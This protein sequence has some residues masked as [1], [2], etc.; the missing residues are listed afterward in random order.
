MFSKDKKTL[1]WIRNVISAETHKLVILSFLRAVQA[2]ALTAISLSLKK[3][4]DAAV[5]RDEQILKQCFPMLLGLILLEIILFAVTKYLSG[6][7][8]ARAEM[9]LRKHAFSSLMLRAYDK[10][11]A[12]HS[13]DWTGRITTESRIIA[14]GIQ[15][16]VPELTGILV[17]LG[18]AVATLHFIIPGS[19]P[20]ILAAGMLM[21]VCA[22]FLRSSLIRYHSAIQISDSRACGMLQEQISS[23]AVIRSFS[24]ENRSA[25]MMRKEFDK[26]QDARRDWTRFIS[27]C[28]GGVHGAAQLGFLLGTAVCCFGVFNGQM[29]PGTMTALI[30][31]VQ[32]LT[33]PISGLFGIVPNYYAIIACAE[34]LQDIDQLPLDRLADLISVDEVRRYYRDELQEFGMQDIS[35]SYDPEHNEEPVLD[36]F[37][38]KVRKGEFLALTGRSGS[39]KSTVL[40][41][42]MGLYKPSSGY[43]YLRNKDGSEIELDASWRMLFAYIPQENGLMSGTIREGIC[44]GNPE[45]MGNDARIRQALETACAWNFVSQLDGGIDAVLGEHGFGL[46]E[47]QMQRLAIARALLAGRPVMMLDEATSALDASTETELL[48]NLKTLSDV[49]VIAVTHRP[50]AVELADRVAA[51]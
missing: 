15:S 36:G 4:V 5:S 34:R 26:V 30:S 42:L 38:M 12:V 48:K 24:G 51:L 31:L 46:S 47:G 9:T 8:F 28:T 23:L 39:G 50:A 14:Q 43:I 37:S 20:V 29:S 44:L 21:A 1:A 19:T 16:L 17:Q 22:A 7:F 35:F 10:V 18:C 6:I 25:E 41:L 13:G 33:S 2:V 3:L 27:F 49:T 40:K 45:L 11:S 32:Q